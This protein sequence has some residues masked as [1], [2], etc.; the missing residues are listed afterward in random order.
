MTSI[1]LSLTETVAFLTLRRWIANFKHLAFYKGKYLFTKSID[2]F[3]DVRII[4]FFNVSNDWYN[5]TLT[6]NGKETRKK[7]QGTVTKLWRESCVENTHYICESSSFSWLWHFN[8]HYFKAQLFILCDS[9]W[10]YHDRRMRQD[11]T[12]LEP[13]VRDESNSVAELSAASACSFL[14]VLVS[15]TFFIIISVSPASFHW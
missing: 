4:H 8:A 3:L 2:G 15:W 5:E 10:L 7:K 12:C 1:H 13:N 6:G 9:K 11:I 14:L